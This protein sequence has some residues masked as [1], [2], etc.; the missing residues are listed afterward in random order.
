MVWSILTS[1][2]WIWNTVYMYVRTMTTKQLRTPSECV[3]Q[4]SMCGPQDIHTAWDLYSY[5]CVYVRSV[6]VIVIATMNERICVFWRKLRAFVMKQRNS[7]CCLPTELLA[8]FFYLCECKNIS[9][10]WWFENMHSSTESSW[11]T[12]IKQCLSLLSDPRYILC[13]C[14]LWCFLYIVYIYQVWWI[15]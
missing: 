15:W 8:S 13:F 6:R 12:I 10:T 11:W 9:W 5:P 7:F 4:R 14:L 1:T 2:Y 3:C